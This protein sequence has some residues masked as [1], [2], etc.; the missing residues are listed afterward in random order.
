MP[1]R[2]NKDKLDPAAAYNIEEWMQG[3]EED[4][5]EVEVRNGEVTNHGTEWRNT[6]LHNYQETLPVD[7]PLQG[8]GVLIR[9]VNRVPISQP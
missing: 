2:N 3:L 6:H 1:P 5:S 7:F 8:E 9:Q 4:V